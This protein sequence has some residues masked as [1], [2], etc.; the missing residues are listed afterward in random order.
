MGGVANG[1]LDINSISADDILVE[2]SGSTPTR[3]YVKAEVGEKIYNI[4]G[5]PYVVIKFSDACLGT[6][7]N[8][9]VNYLSAFL[10]W[11]AA[12][13]KTQAVTKGGGS[14]SSTN[15]QAKFICGVPQATFLNE[16]AKG[17]SASDMNGRRLYPPAVFPSAAVIPM[18]SNVDT[19]GPYVSSNFGTSAG[20]ANVEQN[21]DLAPWVFGGLAPMNAAGQALANSYTTALNQGETGSVTLAGLPNL[22][23]MGF[24]SGANLTGVNVSFGSSGVTTN[25]NFQTYTPKFGNLTRSAVDQL[26]ISA[27][28]RQKQLQFLRNQAIMAHNINRKLKRV[29]GGTNRN[30]EAKNSIADSQTLHRV[31]VGEVADWYDQTS[32][33]SQRTV[34]GLDT[35]SKSVLELRYDYEKKAFMSFDGLFGPISKQ[36]GGTANLPRY[37]TFNEN[38][39][40]VNRT[41]GAPLAPQPPFAIGGCNANTMDQYN[42]PINRKYA[43]PLTNKVS[44]TNHHHEGDGAGHAVDLLGRGGEIPEKGMLMNMIP[45]DDAS[46]YSEDYRFL[47]LRGP[48]VLHAWGYDTDGKPVPNAADSDSNAANGNF[49]TESLKDKFLKDWLNKPKTWPVA[50]V[51]LRFDRERGM[52]VS[53]QAYRI[54]VAKI[55]KKVDA[56]GTGKAV[57]I[58]TKGGNK[59]YKDLYDENGNKIVAADPGDVT[60]ENTKLPTEEEKQY[61]WVLVNV[62]ACEQQYYCFSIGGDSSECRQANAIDENG[63]PGY[64]DP[65]QGF[66]PPV[67]GPYASCAGNPCKHYG[68]CCYDSGLNFE[69]A[70][71]VEKQD[72]LNYYKGDFKSETE[73]GLCANIESECQRKG[74]CCYYDN[75]DGSFYGCDDNIPEK[76]CERDGGVHWLGASCS[77]APCNRNPNNSGIGACCYDTGYGP[78]CDENVPTQDCLDFYN[79][80]SFPDKTCSDIDFLCKRHGSC[81]YYNKETGEFDGCDSPIPEWDCNNDTGTHH[82]GATCDETYCPEFDSTTTTAAPTTNGPTTTPQPCNISDTCIDEI[83][84][85]VW[86]RILERSTFCGTTT[87]GAP[88]TTTTKQP[89]VP[90]P[91]TGLTVTPNAPNR[92]AT[93]SWTAPSDQG[94]PPPVTGYKLTYTPGNGSVNT[95]GTSAVINNLDPGI[96]YNISVVASNTQGDSTPATTQWTFNAWC[97]INFTSQ[98][99]KECK[100]GTAC[101]NAPKLYNSESEC[102]QNCKTTT[103]T[104]TTST[105]TPPTTTRTTTTSTTRP[106]RTVP[107]TPAPPPPQPDVPTID[108]GTREPGPQKPGTGGGGN[109]GTGESII[110]VVDRIG[111]SHNAGS[112]VYAYYDTYKSEYIVLET[113]EEQSAPMIFGQWVDDTIKVEGTVG[114]SAKDNINIGSTVQVVNRLNF[115]KPLATC[116]VRGVAVKFLKS[117]N[118]RIDPN[119]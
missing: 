63:Q 50:P 69:C 27:R 17:V 83:F 9:D 110:N 25:Y 81:C 34:I 45:Q 78:G 58:N 51:D 79:G 104:T 86:K 15:N 24:I 39:P 59:Y 66:L 19:Y 93:V 21:T 7:S 70:D 102:E 62:G 44:S 41:K 2:G 92:S 49:K 56:Y 108:P 5:N 35:L 60:C 109:V 75:E 23:Y 101:I 119:P 52:W 40:L 33:K 14:G 94:E 55:I 57:L 118:G 71:N 64:L 98:D 72:C 48:L 106:P 47:G 111:R 8:D 112:L 76:A 18:R 3:S 99:Y 77:D 65:K 54:V 43:D 53:P 37:A 88:T 115:E 82:F 13:E 100:E 68:S 11:G 80:I 6:M 96:T 30:T 26:K 36:G 20:G 38:T 10:A 42:L 4:G 12:T 113:Y 114:L 89:K 97:C 16:A 22:A 107:P 31:I 28:N 95:G 32:G 84:E 74:A 85:K 117:S 67:F 29:G 87:T 61:E 90:G 103:T 46:R 73:G 1:K 105:T 91:P 116:T